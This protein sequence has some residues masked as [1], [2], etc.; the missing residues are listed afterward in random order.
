MFR[1]NSFINGGHITLLY[2]CIAGL[3]RNITIFPENMKETLLLGRCFQHLKKNIQ[4][5]YKTNF[6]M[7]GIFDKWRDFSQMAGALTFHIMV[8]SSLSA[9]GD[10]R[11]E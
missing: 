10:G 6:K 8:M 7:A 5:F 11:P 1:E 9:G 4:I 3:Y 2:V